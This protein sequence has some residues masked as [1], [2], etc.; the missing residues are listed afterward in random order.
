ME[1]EVFMIVKWV[2]NNVMCLWDNNLDIE[3]ILVTHDL[4]RTI[5]VSSYTNT[6]IK[7]DEYYLAELEES[8]M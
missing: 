7:C 8:G 2:D 5:R 1:L 3:N 4:K 6:F